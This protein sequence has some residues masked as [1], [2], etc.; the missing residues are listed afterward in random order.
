MP[1]YRPE[2]CTGT[3]SASCGDREVCADFDPRLVTTTTG[4][5]MPD[6]DSTSKP[7]HP[8][9]IAAAILG[10]D[11]KLYALP[12]PARH[13]NIL[14]H[15]DVD[16]CTSGFITSDGEYVGREKAFEIASAA[17]QVLP[18]DPAGYNGNMLFTEDLW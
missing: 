4:I 5:V 8:T 16:Q 12:A 14:H 17:G 10:T 18:R 13:H 1:E 9:I 3:P 7:W 11:G 2:G 15:F 6:P